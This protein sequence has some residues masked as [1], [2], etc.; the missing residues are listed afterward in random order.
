M[1][2]A[3]PVQPPVHTAGHA[4]PGGTGAWPQAMPLV[5]VLDALLELEAPDVLL[6]PEEEAVL[7]DEPVV[8]DEAAP[9]APVLP[10]EPKSAPVLGE[11][12][13]KNV[14]PTAE[15]ARSIQPPEGTQSIAPGYHA[16]PGGGD[17]PAA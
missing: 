6:T 4:P 7:P 12:A 17:E 2:H 10:P 9:P 14:A 13:V 11:Q 16:P 15:S 5:D 8:A 1:V 3:P